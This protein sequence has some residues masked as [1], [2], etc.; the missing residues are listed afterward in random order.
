MLSPIHLPPFEDT[1]G[2]ERVT[3]GVLNAIKNDLYF[4]WSELELVS[5]GHISK[6]AGRVKQ[7]KETPFLLAPR[8]VS[9]HQ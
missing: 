8:A 2:E 4:G 3:R 6:N 7:K 1:G 9:E 5:R